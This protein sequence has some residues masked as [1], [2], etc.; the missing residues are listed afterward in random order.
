MYATIK[1]GVTEFHE[2]VPTLEEMQAIVGG[3]IET[4]DR[5]PTARPGIMISIY[6]NEDGIALNLPLT[7]HND[8]GSPIFGDLVLVAENDRSGNTVKATKAE[9]EDAVMRTGI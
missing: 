3:Y 8:Y 6:C 2:G 1:N 5:V 9:L 4:A 7:Y